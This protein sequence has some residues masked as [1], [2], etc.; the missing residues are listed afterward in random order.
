MKLYP[1][2]NLTQKWDFEYKYL[3]KVGFQ[4]QST[5]TEPAYFI[6]GEKVNDYTYYLKPKEYSF[7]EIAAIH[8]FFNEYLIS[9]NQLKD[10]KYTMKLSFVFDCI[11]DYDKISTIEKNPGLERIC[12]NL[13]VEIV[14]NKI[15]PD[16]LEKD[17]IVEVNW[18][19]N[20]LEKRHYAEGVL[21][22]FLEAKRLGYCQGG[23]IALGDYLDMSIFLKIEKAKE[24]EAIEAINKVLSSDEKL[25]GYK[26]ILRD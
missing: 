26:V 8:E 22:K 19:E 25:V 14:V 9:F 1:I 11:D 3:E 13:G 5:V 4:V 23:E 15:N 21:G 2:I 6:D 7:G 17:L 20:S 24:N 18:K 12:K 10:Y 16:L